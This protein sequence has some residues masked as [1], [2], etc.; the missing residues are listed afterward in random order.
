MMR[1]TLLLA[2]AGLIAIGSCGFG[3]SQACFER[4]D[5]K[6]CADNGNDSIEFSG[7]GLQP[8]S[9]VLIDNPELG[10]SVYEVDD[11]GT[12]EP[13]GRMVLAMFEGTPFTFTVTATDADGGLIE[14]VIDISL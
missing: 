4:G 12:F 7:S 3:D 2:G 9:A 6:V 8:D 11:D 10:L 14:G 13:D 1:R 5:A